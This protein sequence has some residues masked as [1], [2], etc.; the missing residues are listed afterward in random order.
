MSPPEKKD[1]S[2]NGSPACGRV[3]NSGRLLGFLIL[4]NLHHDL[5]ILPKKM[6]ISIR[7]SGPKE[8]AIRDLR[9]QAIINWGHLIAA[10]I[11]NQVGVPR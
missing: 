3:N 7:H 6:E 9:I 5:M 8:L 11:G 4:W 10:S 1:A 2:S